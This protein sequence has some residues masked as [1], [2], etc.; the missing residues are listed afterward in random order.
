MRAPSGK[1]PQAE[2]V[3]HKDYGVQAE[4]LAVVSYKM[5]LLVPVAGLMVLLKD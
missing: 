1:A 2:E 5:V 3:L 4:V